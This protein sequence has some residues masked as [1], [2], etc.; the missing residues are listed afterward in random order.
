MDLA[1]LRLKSLPYLHG[2]VFE[3]TAAG[4]VKL[5][6]LMD[7]R[8]PVKHLFARDHRRLHFSSQS[9]PNAAQFLKLR[10]FCDFRRDASPPLCIIS[11]KFLTI[12]YALNVQCTLQFS[13]VCFILRRRYLPVNFVAHN[14]CQGDAWRICVQCHFWPRISRHRNCLFQVCLQSSIDRQ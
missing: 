14:P 7:N 9:L 1:D 8:F 3:A 4:I 6:I 5:G 13:C 12:T 10:I 11:A 2:C